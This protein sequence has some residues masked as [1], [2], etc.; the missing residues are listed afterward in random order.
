MNNS[1]VSKSNSKSPNRR[2]FLKKI[3]LG[4]GAAIGAAGLTNNLQDSQKAFA[5]QTKLG[6]REKIKEVRAYTSPWRPQPEGV[7]LPQGSGW[8]VV[9]LVAAPMSVYP[10]YHDSR[11]SWGIVSMGGFAVEIEDAAGRIG[12][13]SSTGGIPGAF[14]IENHF[15]RFLI[16]QYPHDIEK[17]WDQMWRASMHYGRKGLV[18]MA[19]SAVDLAL[20]DLLGQQ[21]QEPVYAM[22]GGAVKNEISMYATTPNPL[23]AKQMGFWGAK[24]A[25][26]HGP[27]DGL[28]G[29]RA[30]MKMMEKAREQVGDDFEL[31]FD[32]W[33][34]LDVP[35]T[36]DLARALVPCRAKWLEECLPPDNYD[37]LADV[38]A[39]VKS[40][41]LT[42]GEHEYTR[43]GFH[44][45][46]KRRGVD[47]IQPDLNWCGGLSEALKIADLAKA[48]GVY[49]VPHGGSVFSR[50]F[51]ISQTQAPFMEFFIGGPTGD[52]IE[53]EPLL[54]NGKLKVSD[55]PGWGSM[56]NRDNKNNKNLERPFK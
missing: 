6:A 40:C 49:V 2:S 42:T 51:V 36:I 50:H 55:E 41:W 8:E 7:K 35:Y 11:N 1:E 32:C 15:K 48:Y 46:L 33:M 56:V 39:S 14:I 28:E 34:A 20:W 43:Y 12:V 16:D 10:E 44:E 25:L 3:G 9:N 19:I 13:G 5:S 27:A 31:M 53:N 24:M 54:K 29:L 4:T 17:I 38:R 26:P 30:N 47:V 45:I 23:Y 18:V 21:R 37:G 52:K 22:I